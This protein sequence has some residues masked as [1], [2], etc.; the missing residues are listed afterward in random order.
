M[1]KSSVTYYVIGP[2]FYRQQIDIQH[3]IFLRNLNR[4][5][6]IRP[7]IRRLLEYL[8]RAQIRMKSA[9]ECTIPSFVYHPWRNVLLV[10]THFVITCVMCTVSLWKCSCDL[11][12]RCTLRC[13]SFYTTGRKSA[14]HRLPNRRLFVTRRRFAEILQAPCVNL[15]F[16]QQPSWQ[17]ISAQ[18]ET[19]KPR[20]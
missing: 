19:L 20:S 11:A 8:W 16:L 9:H 5:H 1:T 3:V 6:A 18:E 4:R 13:S 17:H 7:L 2:R 15:T 10:I 12:T 14:Y